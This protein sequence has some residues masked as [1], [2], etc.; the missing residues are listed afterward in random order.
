MLSLNN[1][2]K[3]FASDQG[4]VQAIHEVSLV[5]EAGEFFTL[6]GPSGCGK[7][8]TLRCVAGLE[9]PD[10]GEI[11]LDGQVVFSR[12]KNLSVP[13]HL[14]DL[15]MVFQSY[16]IWPHMNVFDNV[17]YPLRYGVGHR[18]RE[19]DIRSRVIEALQLVHMEQVANRSATQLSG[20]QQQRVALARALSRRPRVLLLDEPLSNLDAKLREEMRVE[21][22][23][24]LRRLG[25]TAVYVTHD[26]MEALAMSDRIAVML[27]GRVVQEGTPQEIYLRPQH[28]FVAS[29]VGSI[30]F[31]NGR[32]KSK[33]PDT[34]AVVETSVGQILCRCPAAAGEGQAVTIGIRPE[35]VTVSQS[36]NDILPNTFHGEVSRVVF[37][38][39]VVA[40][41][42]SV[43]GQ[44]LKVKM[45]PQDVVQRGEK[46]YVTLHPELCLVMP[47]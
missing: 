30:N 21:L 44:T 36:L 31:L 34:G 11:L 8:T 20:G 15:G 46:V 5:V 41:E 43:G 22:R 2:T 7:T 3:N 23:D 33:E 14:R 27:D 4:K 24:L 45:R 42:V 29:F 40:G 32:L 9:S 26:Q 25:T 19:K 13:P 47:T 6:L 12:R 18:L 35:S 38:G 17:A 37:L 10:S 1:V 39:D 28:K 16:A